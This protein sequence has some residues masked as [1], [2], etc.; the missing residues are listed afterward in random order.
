MDS[1]KTERATPEGLALFDLNP[2]THVLIILWTRHHPKN[3]NHNFRDMP[4]H[5]SLPYQ[6]FPPRE[7]QNETSGAAILYTLLPRI[8][9]QRLLH[10]LHFKGQLL[11]SVWFS[12]P[13]CKGSFQGGSTRQQHHRNY[14]ATE[15]FKRTSGTKR[16]KILAPFR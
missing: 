12:L 10:T 1:R 2:G 15:G 9:G 6:A 13:F 5:P 11:I 8:C 16:I 7:G 4:S 3:A 14:E